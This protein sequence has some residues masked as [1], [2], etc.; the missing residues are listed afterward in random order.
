MTPEQSTQEWIKRNLRVIGGEPEKIL[1]A[2][3]V[4]GYTL[5][6]IRKDEDGDSSWIVK[7]QS[8][9][10]RPHS[11]KTTDITEQWMLYVVAQDVNLISD[12]AIK[13]IWNEVARLTVDKNL[14]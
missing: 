13:L 2:M 10:A 3:Q 12:V 1:R 11:V 7:Y 14:R 4:L 8:P 6:F 5:V 9:S